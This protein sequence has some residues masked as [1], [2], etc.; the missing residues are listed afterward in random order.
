MIVV[1]DKLLR[2]ERA[3]AVAQQN[4]WLAWLFV[5]RDYAK[6]NHVFDELIKTGGPESPRLPEGLL[7]GRDR[8]DRFRKQILRQSM[9]Q[10][11]PHSGPCARRV[12]A[13]F[14][15]HLEQGDHRSISHTQ[16]QNPQHL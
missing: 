7:S 15:R 11:V 5:L 13:R 8:D 14:E 6:K 9:Y 3:Q 10:L 4:A 16:W 1:E 12:R 2:G